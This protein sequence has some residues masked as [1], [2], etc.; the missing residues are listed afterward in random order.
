VLRPSSASGLPKPLFW[1]TKVAGEGKHRLVAAG[2]SR[3][4][5]GIAPQ[6]FANFDLGPGLNFGFQG[7]ALNSQFLDAAVSKTNDKQPAILLLG[8][9]PNAFTPSAERSNGFDKAVSDVSPFDSRY[10]WRSNALLLGNQT[11]WKRL[12]IPMDGWKPFTTLPTK[13]TRC[14]FIEIASI[15]TWLRRNFLIGSCRISPH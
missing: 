10:C 12:T 9:T 13:N 15:K 11:N 6:E 2:D 4:L 5:R 3:T 1:R 14:G 8:I 7:A